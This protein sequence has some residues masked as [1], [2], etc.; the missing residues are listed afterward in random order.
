MRIGQRRSLTAAQQYFS[1][2]SS[3]ICRG[4]GR[5]RAGQL[6]WRYLATPLPLSRDYEVRICFRQGSIPKIFVDSPDLQILAVG[7]RIPHLYE[8][9]P[10]QQLC[11]Y[12]PKR[13]EWQAWMRLDETIV[14]WA[15]LWLFYFEEWL[16]SNDWKG[17]GEHPPVS[18]AA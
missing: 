6:T 13:H 2:S 14:P 4:S 18:E 17:G 10:P 8:Q 15:A 5:L 9:K 7:R 16:E 11:L 1:L 3:P 12:L